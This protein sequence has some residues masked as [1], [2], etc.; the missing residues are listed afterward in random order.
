M[1]RNIFGEFMNI[2]FS[3][4]NNGKVC[5]EMCTSVLK[6]KACYGEFIDL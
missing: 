4:N 2:C 5:A 3:V 1:H 6:Y